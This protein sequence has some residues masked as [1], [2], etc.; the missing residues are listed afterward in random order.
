[1]KLGYTAPA[2]VEQAGS[3]DVC[4]TVVSVHNAEPNVKHMVT[5]NAGQ[6]YVNHVCEANVKSLCSVDVSEHGSNAGY[7][8]VDHVGEAATNVK[9]VCNN[10]VSDHVA[11]LSQHVSVGKPSY[12]TSP[13]GCPE[14]ADLTAKVI[15]PQGVSINFDIPLVMLGHQPTGTAEV[16]SAPGGEGECSDIT[17]QSSVILNNMN[18]DKDKVSIESDLKGELHPI[19]DINHTEVEEQFVNSILHAN[20]FKLCETYDEVDSEIYNA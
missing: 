13:K 8:N 18:M 7:A 15:S 19:Y 14:G 16:V 12:Q 20:Q 2:D 17:A 1:M 10:D 3:A 11:T 4:H 9:L 5:S 6:T